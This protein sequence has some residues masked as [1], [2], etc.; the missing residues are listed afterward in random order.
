MCG[1]L[2]HLGKFRME[3][4]IVPAA[5]GILY[6]GHN[7]QK[8]H[9]YPQ[10][11]FICCVIPFGLFTSL[12]PL[13]QAVSWFPWQCDV[14]PSNCGMDE[15]SRCPWQQ[16]RWHG[17]LSTESNIHPAGICHPQRAIISNTVHTNRVSWIERKS[18]VRFKSITHLLHE[19]KTEFPFWVS[20]VAEVFKHFLGPLYLTI[21]KNYL[22]IH[23][24]TYTLSPCRSV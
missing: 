14:A 12:S 16:P 5:Y 10:S 3:K 13:Y 9:Y 20:H 19:M 24:H 11:P 8:T 21:T 23:T 18:Y 22:H 6:P 17:R 2:G 15:A 1:T 7:T 4:H